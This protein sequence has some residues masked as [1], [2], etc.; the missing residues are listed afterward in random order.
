MGLKGV[1]C[2]I[3]MVKCRQNTL[4]NNYCFHY[5]ACSN[6]TYNVLFLCFIYCSLTVTINLFWGVYI[7][8]LSYFGEYIYH[9]T[10]YLFCAVYGLT[11]N[12]FSFVCGFWQSSLTDWMLTTV[13]TLTITPFTLTVLILYWNSSIWRLD[14][15][16][17]FGISEC[18]WTNLKKKKKNEYR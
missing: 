17:S 10:L 14:N 1:Y 4:N 11:R 3:P 7:L 6:K 16:W 8:T 13:F 12:L 5:S 15:I 18:I 2:I 9:L